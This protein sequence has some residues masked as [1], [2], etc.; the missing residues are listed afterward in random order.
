MPSRMKKARSGAS[1]P[2]TPRPALRAI[3]A[4]SMS[5]SSDMLSRLTAVD[6]RQDVRP[7]AAIV[8]GERRRAA[9]IVAI[10]RGDA[11]EILDVADA[12]IEALRADRRKH[13]RGLA[14][15]RDAVLARSV[16]ASVAES[17]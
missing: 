13:M 16:R 4:G 3:C 5:D 10:F 12:E 2:S 17:G 14:D 6:A 7:P 15:Q 11:N 8:G 1:A 9:G